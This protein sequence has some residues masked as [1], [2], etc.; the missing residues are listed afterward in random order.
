MSWFYFTLFQ[1]NWTL[2]IPKDWSG[3][4]VVRNAD[5][6][7]ALQVFITKYPSR[8]AHNSMLLLSALEV[9]PKD[10]PSPEVC[11]RATMWAL[12]ELA[13]ALYIAQFSTEDSKDNIKRVQ[14]NQYQLL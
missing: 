10:Y 14:N 9:L 11:T 13:S 6:L 12:P 8:V 4:I 2:L 7:R 1:L 5:Y 3:P